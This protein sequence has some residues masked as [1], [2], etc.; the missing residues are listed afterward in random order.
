[1]QTR[2][3]ARQ[4]QDAEALKNDPGRQTEREALILA[5]DK[6]QVL[7]PAAYL[8]GKVVYWPRGQFAEAADAF[9]R[10]IMIATEETPAR[11][12]GDDLQEL[13]DRAFAAKALAANF[14]SAHPT[15]DGTIPGYRGVKTIPMPI[16]FETN[17]ADLTPKGRECALELA[18][19]IKQ[20]NLATVT[21][22]GHTDDRGDDTLNDKLSSERVKTVEAFLRAQGVTARIVTVARGKREP[23]IPP[24]A[25]N[26]SPQQIWELNRRVVWRRG[27]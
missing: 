12:R 25:A 21:I 2:R 10:A 17:K 9:N 20:Q 23:F 15:R 19:A 24:D 5:A 3:A 11:I 22:E 14:V 4:I 18:N 7:W 13:V 1:L 16:Q 6:P 26:L 27:S 8:A